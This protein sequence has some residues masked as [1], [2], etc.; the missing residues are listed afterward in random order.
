ME[1][2]FDDATNNA[3]SSASPPDYEFGPVANVKTLSRFV[4]APLGSEN[5]RFPS[6][7]P[8]MSLPSEKRQAPRRCV[9]FV[10]GEPSYGR[11][12]IAEP[13]THHH[14]IVWQR[15]YPPFQRADEIESEH[16]EARPVSCVGKPDAQFVSDG[17]GQI[18]GA[19][20]PFVGKHDLVGHVSLQPYC[21]S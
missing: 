15:R 21:L 17:L 5:G 16:P 6:L 14:R 8:I 10:D 13:L 12:R 1:N 7:N 18:V 19:I 3:Q 9:G 20:V 4:A 11:N 2:G